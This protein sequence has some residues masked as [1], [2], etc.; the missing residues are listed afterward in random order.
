[1]RRQ[2]LAAVFP[3]MQVSTVAGKR[4]PGNK[5]RPGELIFFPDALAGEQV[6]RV[7]GPPSGDAESCASE[8][9]ASQRKSETRELSFMTYRW[10]QRSDYLVVLQYE[11]TGV[12]PAGACW[13]IGRLVHL[14]GND[15]GWRIVE[16]IEFDTQRHGGFE[17][18]E[19]TSLS[20]HGIDELLVESN[21]DGAGTVGSSLFVYSLENGRFEQW[22]KTTARVESIDGSFTQGLD[23]SKTRATYAMS[24]C[25]V[26]TDLTSPD[27]EPYR[28]PRV[29]RPCY[30]RGHR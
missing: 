25:F 30:P 8:D 20:G 23:V 6:Y 2:I 5:P 1:V 26:K 15:A 29:S 14:V 17:R 28:S 19:M 9:V 21:W 3:S 24:F 27:G 22:L 4:H 13:S 18:I 10:P 12:G 7:I 11:F 16:G